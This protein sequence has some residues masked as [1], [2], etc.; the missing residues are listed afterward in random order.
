MNRRTRWI[1]IG[2]VVAILIVL[3]LGWRA[4]RRSSGNKSSVAQLEQAR[5]VKQRRR[6]ASQQAAFR[7]RL[8]RL[9]GKPQGTR[10][11]VGTV[12][13]TDGKTIGSAEIRVM[14]HGGGVLQAR[15]LKNGR[16]GLLGVPTRAERMEVWA[17]GYETKVFAPLILPADQRVRWDV[18]LTPA[19][20]VHGVVLQGRQPAPDA[21]VR[22]YRQGSRQTLGRTRTDLGGRFSM[23]FSG[24]TGGTFVVS[25]YHPQ[26]GKAQKTIS[27]P[28][29]VI[30][31]LPG[32]GYVEGR[33]VDEQGRPVTKFSLSSS[34][35]ARASR[36]AVS[37][38]FSNANGRF[39]LGPLT[40]GRQVLYAIV[41]GYQP[42]RSGNLQIRTGETLRGVE[43]KLA[44]S[45]ELQG[46]VTDAST[47][48]PIKG[49][50]VA[51]TGWG[52]RVVSRTA[53]SVT[54]TNGHYTLRSVPD[55]RTSLSVRAPGYQPLLAGGVECSGG[56]R[57]KRDFSLTPLARG[58][59][60]GGQLMGVGA[61][62]R[63]TGNGVLIQSLLAGGPAE[64][65][66]NKGDVV[67][68]VGDLD[69]ST[70][71]I[72]EVAQAI[73]GESGTD[74]VLWVRRPGQTEPQR[75]VITRARVT[76]PSRRRR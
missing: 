20:G 55:S 42:G 43:I 17:R 57:C 10:M 61:V 70:M 71:G 27:G 65:L 2:L 34:S 56:Q 52:P 16:Y 6:L 35:L 40:A 60:P 4:L 58:E 73:R 45:G 5:K 38:P 19:K 37:Q 23:P 33:V 66:L 39:R 29:E 26:L 64:A 72:R 51:P 54:D 24:D 44:G 9:H 15:S 22:F 49:A 7:N 3:G 14:L 13:S 53:G 12:T 21:V 50:M 62:L 63:K 36:G 48:Q 59:R 31:Q 8:R 11:V 18:T 75:I 41:P 32:G 76:M 67:V 46:Q 25:A 30:L 74:V 1:L 47:G 28:G 68:M 69:V